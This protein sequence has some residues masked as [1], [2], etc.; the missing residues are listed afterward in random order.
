M[1]EAELEP[2][3]LVLRPMLFLLHHTASLGHARPHALEQGGCWENRQAK[4]RG[5][6]SKKKWGNAQHLD[7]TELGLTFGSATSF[8]L[9]KDS[10]FCKTKVFPWKVVEGIQ[11]DHL[12]KWFPRFWT[13]NCSVSIYY[14]QQ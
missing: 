11:W 9:L 12:C 6:N 1:E 5:G 4:K 7:P 14:Y 8:K 10:I 13:Q 3:P 2:E